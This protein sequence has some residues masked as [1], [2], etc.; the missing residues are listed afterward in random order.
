MGFGACWIYIQSLTE[1]TG[2]LDEVMN[3]GVLQGTYADMPT[4]LLEW[5]S[6]LCTGLNLPVRAEDEHLTELI[7]RCKAIP[8][9][10]EPVQFWYDPRTAFALV[11]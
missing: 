2:P 4:V 8:T 3:R 1:R 11:G 6:R 10:R 9:A 5:Y 7:Q